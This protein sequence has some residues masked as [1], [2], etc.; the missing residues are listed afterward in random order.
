MPREINAEGYALIKE[1]EQGPMGGPALVPYRCPAGKLTNGWGNTHG[2]VPGQVITVEQAQADLERNLDWAE[3]CVEKYAPG[4]NENE[5][6]AMVSLCFNVGPDPATGFPSSSVARLHK[7]GDKQG[8]ARSFALWNKMRDPRTGALVAVAGLTRRRAAEAALYLKPVNEIVIVPS[9]QVVEPP[10]GNSTSATVIAGGVSVAAGV[11]SVADQISQIE[12]IITSLTTAG[13]SVQN[14]LKLGGVTLSVIA[15]AA[16]AF[17][18]IR[19]IIK[20]RRG[21]VVS[22]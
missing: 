5:F 18:L 3:S 2:V 6:S 20:K 10:K 15:L 4:A 17:V 7:A 8:A 13:A 1:F 9:P 22:T 11:G 12:P 14:L 19:Y 16:V 21:E